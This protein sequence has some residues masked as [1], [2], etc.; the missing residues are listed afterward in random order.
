[1]MLERFMQNPIELIKY[2]VLIILAV[3]IY[4]WYRSIPSGK[5]SILKNPKA[6][7]RL[8]RDFAVITEAHFDPE[9]DDY[10]LVV[11]MCLN[12]SASLEKESQPDE[13]FKLLPNA[14]Q[15]AMS[16]GYLFEDSR[17]KL[18]DFFHYN[19]EPL[20]SAA[21]KAAEEVIGGEFAGLYS[22][23]YV[24]FDENNEEVSLSADEIKTLNERYSIFMKEHSGEIYKKAADYIR[25]NK[26]VFLS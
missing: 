13:A 1:M 18:S 2:I 3:I 20:L 24:M 12:I 10:M 23:E 16:L 8:K 26:N 4:I 14:K 19:S 6:E 25:Q 15:Y 7:K 9:R 21:G 5:G 11:G 17:E 22:K